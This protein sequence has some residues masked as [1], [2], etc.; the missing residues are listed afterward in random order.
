MLINVEAREVAAVV[1]AVVV[2]AV[3][4]VVVVEAVDAVDLQQLVLEPL[5]AAR[6]AEQHLPGEVNTRG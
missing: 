6:G 5:Q 4:V 3:V 2:V 1:E